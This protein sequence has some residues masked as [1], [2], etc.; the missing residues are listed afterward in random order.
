MRTIPRT[1]MRFGAASF[2]VALA[3]SAAGCIL[4]ADDTHK[5]FQ[6]TVGRQLCDLKAAR[7]TGA[8]NDDEYHHTKAKL[9]SDCR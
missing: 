8:I 1:L 4:V 2:V 5:T 3:L 6:P 9:L 7:D